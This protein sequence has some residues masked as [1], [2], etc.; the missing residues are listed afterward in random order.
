MSRHRIIGLVGALIVWLLGT[1]SA[2]ASPGGPNWSQTVDGMLVHL[3]IMSTQ[4]MRQH[5]DQYPEHFIEGEP[6][7]G[8][9]M[10]HV[11]VTVFERSSGERITNAD[12]EMRVSPIGLA[13]RQKHLHAM[14][15]RGAACYCNY[16]YMPPTDSY[17]ISVQ[18]R[19]PGV[20]VVARA[21]FLYTHHRGP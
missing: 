12:V 16:F 4:V 17:R 1:F 19:R 6:P 2:A 10:Y 15:V 8:R 21:K 7:A 14:S 18:I 11:L 3:G 5:P 13:G 20:P 9:H